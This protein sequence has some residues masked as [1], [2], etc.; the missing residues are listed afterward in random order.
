MRRPWIPCV[1]P[2]DFPGQSR[3]SAAEQFERSLSFAE[4]NV[5]EPGEEALT[6]DLRVLWDRSKTDLPQF[7]KDGFRPIYVHLTNRLNELIEVNQRGMF[8]IADH[9]TPFATGFFLAALIFFATFLTALWLADGLALR[10][11]SPSRTF[12]EALR[13]KPLPGEKLRLPTPTSLEIQHPDLRNESALETPLRIPK[14]EHRGD[15]AAKE[16]ARDRA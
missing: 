16:Q 10:I 13:N 14:D 11:A 7:S 9:T 12:A 2:G 4:G 8:R 15:S 1:S 6:R 3:E 5:T